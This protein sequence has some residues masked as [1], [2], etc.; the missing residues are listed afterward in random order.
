[1]P[2]Y[3]VRDP[4]TGITLK[5]KGD[6]PPTERE[7]EEIFSEYA[8]SKAV[9]Q[10][11]PVAAEEPS[12]A[13]IGGGLAA[14]VA[15]GTAGQVAG[16]SLAPFTLGISYPVLAFGSG[17]SGSLA[18]QKIEGRDDVSLGR[19]LFAGAVNL[20]PGSGAAK[21][22]TKVGTML[23]KEAIRGAALGAG[24]AT[25]MAVLDEGRPPTA[26]EL[27]TYGAFGGVSAPFVGLALKGIGRLS[28]RSQEMVESFRGKT[29]EEVKKQLDDIAVNGTP[30]Q[31]AAAAEIIDSVGAQLGLVRADAAKSAQ[32]SAAVMGASPTKSAAESAEILKRAI[33][34][35]EELQAQFKQGKTE[36]ELTQFLV[37]NRLAGPEQVTLDPQSPIEQVRLD[38]IESR[39]GQSARERA[40]LESRL[41]KIPEEI[42]PTT[43]DVLQDVQNIPG[44][45]GR[46][47]ARRMGLEG[48]F[49]TPGAAFAIGRTGAGA[50]IGASQGETPEERLQYAAMGAA[51][52]AASTPK[53]FKAV[54]SGGEGLF[55]KIKNKTPKEV[56]DMIR[57]GEI[58]PR[59]LGPSSDDATIVG[60]AEPLKRE[61]ERIQLKA[62]D[63]L[64][65]ELATAKPSELISPKAQKVSRFF[66]SIFPS[67]VIGSDANDAIIDFNNSVAGMNELGS[68]LRVNI[69]K[70]IRKDANPPEAQR[71]INAYLDG[72][73]DFLPGNLA[74]IKTDLDLGREKILDLQKQLLA[75]IDS[76]ITR[77]PTGAMGGTV[78]PNGERIN[79]IIQKS[80]ERGNYLTREYRFFT[81][82]NY[83]PSQ[84]Q[85]KSAIQELADSF[86]I[87]SGK[88]GSPISRER[89]L[90][91][92]DEYLNEL[93]NKKLSEVGSY[94]LFP[95]SIDGF[96]K[97]RKDI[98]PAVRGYLGEIVDP[99]ERVSGTMSRLAKAV[100]RDAT[101]AE[102]VRS[103]AKY[104]IGSP[105]RTDPRMVPLV[106]RRKGADGP[107]LYV[108]P[109]VQDAINQLYLDGS[110]EQIGNMAFNAIK[111]I[112]QS[113]VSLSKA[114]KVL[115]NPPSYAVQFYGNSA[116]LLAQGINPFGNGFSRGIRLALSEF[117]PIERINQN[118]EARKALLNDIQDMVKYGIKGANITDS[119]I[120]S[121]LESGIFGSTIRKALDPASKLYTVPDTVG[122]YVSWKHNQKLI[123]Q[124]F[125]SAS[126]E[127]VKKFAASITNDT[128][129]NYQRLSSSVKAASRVGLIPQFASFTLEF[130]R[131]QYHQGQ[132]IRQMLNGTFGAGVQ[133]LGQADIRRMQVEGTKRLAAITSVYAG[134]AAAI[135]M[136]NNDSGVDQKTENALRDIGIP[137]YDQS[138]MLAMT[139]DKNTMTGK[140][141]NPSYIIPHATALSAFEAGLNGSPASSVGDIL[142]QELIGEGSFFARSLYSALLGYDPS[143]GKPITYQTKPFE[144]AKESLMFFVDDAF[145]PGIKREVTKLSQAQRGQG[146]LAVE[147]VVA[148]QFGARFNPINV[149]LSARFKF[150]TLADRAKLATSDYTASRDYRKL[151]P[152]EI[153]SQYEISNQAKKDAMAV[154]IQHI[155]SLR[156]LGMDDNKIIQL[157]QEG[158]IGS[159]DILAAF[160]GNVV[161]IPRIKRVTPSDYWSENLSMLPQAKQREEILKL[162]R[163]KNTLGLAKDLMRTYEQEIRYKSRGISPQDRLVLSLGVG[164]GERA[165][166]LH[167]KAMQAPDYNSF[168]QNAIRR[169]LATKEVVMQMNALR[170]TQGKAIY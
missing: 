23:G 157:M 104:G 92:A 101:D 16:A 97:G 44:I 153:E 54:L 67:R 146:E 169:N 18:A 116:N 170:Q 47:G 79:S 138:R 98:G 114:V 106:L 131:N 2:I 155:D 39:R 51:I 149:N 62:A 89:A 13:Q 61:A 96:L 15:I 165:E 45:G 82:K 6:S 115:L 90:G 74:S 25:A 81:D 95:S 49:I 130:A 125:P 103:M 124:I 126:P 73:T 151:S 158:G 24:E 127:L 164:D 100:Y 38:I 48:G 46:A 60:I 5:L 134:T 150:K 12:L 42:L 35:S 129:M 168:L 22:G 11:Q 10:Q 162:S 63:E 28:G 99:G 111:D 55:N 133:G 160:D 86:Y 50:A 140:Y 119:D 83:F 163:D 9:K 33:E 3:T 141:A 80:M 139:F 56:D 59:E 113:G 144:R 27:L 1:M 21:T 166:Y 41:N 109:H 148:R 105:T 107:Q 43:E 70:T 76:G 161:D 112:Y 69:E 75:N 17:V 142:K 118:P 121:G 20:I 7:L 88:S 87:E 29:N 135:K 137:D 120:R 37:N 167:R 34:R 102:I 32:E 66:S 110:D 68:R 122:R 31:K 143:T 117:G 36:E 40:R 77:D 72:D 26:E 71:A 145:S 156:T 64:Q 4:Q 58:I 57:S 78:M 123:G 8:A 30:D 85:R 65:T 53:L 93:D 128:Y 152:E 91:M 52:G 147:D 19:A 84:E 136:F 159:K 154:A 132:I 94:N 14:E 108:Q